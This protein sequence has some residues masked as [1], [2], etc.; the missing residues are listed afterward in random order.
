MARPVKISFFILILLCAFYFPNS[1]ESV[2]AQATVI[3]STVRITVCGNGIIES[4]E[5]CDPPGG[6]NFGGKTCRTFGYSGGSLFCQSDC[7]INTSNCIREGGGGGGGGG[8]EPP[9]TETKVIIK[10]LA[11]PSSFITLLQD[12]R[13]GGA[14]IADPQA[15]FKF[16]IANITPGI[17]TF[18]IF[19]EDKAGRKSITFSFTSSVTAGVTTTISGIFLPPTIEIDKTLVQKGETLNIL[20]QTAPKSEVT[21]FV[22]SK[23]I[24][25]KTKAGNDGLWFY[26]FDTTPLAE[27]SHS[28]R[29]KA[30]SPE[31]LLSIFSQTLAFNIGKKEIEIAYSIRGDINGD[32]KV[33]LIDFSILLYNWGKP[34]NPAA[35]LNNDGKVN[36]TDFSIMLY[37]WTG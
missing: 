37:W 25:E 11:Y 19:A 13:V 26:P 14:T 5:S 36:L 1:L 34:K 21:I 29:A 35:D 7:R 2:S 3:Q 20:G 28:T 18:G 32:K 33:N 31:G 9:A 15:N 17:W 4:E 24:A 27:G 6:N 8:Y 23:E 12:G 22:H 16:E 30:T 10:G